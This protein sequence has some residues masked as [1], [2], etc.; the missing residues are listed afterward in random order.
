[1]PR[2]PSLLL[3]SLLAS[4]LRWASGQTYYVSASGDDGASGT[5][6][7]AAWATL[8]RAAAASP[9]LGPGGAILL[10]RGD[11]WT[12][13]TAWF[14]TGLR[15]SASSPITIGA[16]GPAAQRPR[17]ARTPPAAGPTMTVDNSSGVAVIGIEVVGGENGVAFTHDVRPGESESVF[18][19]LSVSD[20]SFSQIRGLHY[21]ASSGS[22]W[23][24][25]LAFAA[26]HA[27][28]VLTNV[29]VTHN[30]VN[31]SDVF[32]INSVPYAGFTR[33]YVSG[34]TVAANT[35]THASY[36]TLFLDT[37]SHVR[38]AGNVFARNTPAQLFVA[39]TTDIIMGSLNASVSIEGNEISWRGE[40]QP[41]GPDG[42]AVDFETAADGVSFSKNYVYRS[43][44]AGIMVF[45]H[46][47]TSVNLVIE[48]NTMLY[49]GCGQTRDDHGG[50]AFMF[51][52]SSGTLAG[53]VFATCP[54]TPLF[55]ERVPGAA[56]GWSFRDNA[57]DGANGTIVVALDAPALVATGDAGAISLRAS[58]V[59]PDAELRFTV[60]GSK[61]G[62]ASA[63]WPAGGEL[64][65]PPR[66][67]A[68][69][70]KCLPPPA[71]RLYE[72]LAA[73]LGAT[74]LVESPVGGGIYAPAVAPPHGA[75][76]K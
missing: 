60:D 72:R 24:S 48:G 6:P 34:L 49:N 23:G 3:L 66:T 40:F 44:G 38:I 32:Y 36:N 28:V 17:L 75:P 9:S 26:R 67:V 22:W 62:A 73:A 53:N 35:I 7:S 76:L 25:A 69:N 51:Q 37:T 46:A 68:V 1:M 59:V 57:I 63:L 52:N 27:G 42:C 11:T 39:G 33:S 64:V 13:S 12:L 50:I 71:G 54:G 16:Y 10:R 56:A 18:D 31:D 41:G 43:F 14:L 58:C 4:S 15:G 70:A 20:C 65:L 61:P 2:C 45:G 8:T 55:Y 21:N 19:A 30:L 74:L 29:N 5:S 47:T